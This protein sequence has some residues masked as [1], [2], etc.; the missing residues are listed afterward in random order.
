M[1]PKIRYPAD[2][3][4]PSQM[5]RAV[6]LLGHAGVKLPANAG[7]REV[8]MAIAVREGLHIHG[9]VEWQALIVR[10]YLRFAPADVVTPFRPPEFREYRPGRRMIEACARARAWCWEGA[11]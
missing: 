11:Q 2:P 1:N 3:I 8:A 9:G 10:R 5:H 7:L 6:T 4:T